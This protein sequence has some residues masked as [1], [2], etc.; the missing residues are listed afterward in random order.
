MAQQHLARHGLQTGPV[1]LA[2]IGRTLVRYCLGEDGVVEQNRLEL[3]LTIQYACFHPG[4]PVAYVA[5]SNGGV[6]IQGDRHC[7]AQVSLG[8]T[9]MRIVAEP[10]VLP[11]RPLHASVG[12]GRNRL[13]IAYNRPAAVTIHD[14]DNDGG[15]VPQRRLLAEGTDR[16]GHFPH[17]VI[18]M[19]GS[20]GL[21]LTCRGDDAGTANAENPGSLRV[22]RDEGETLA[23]VQAVAPN[24]GFGF[25]PRNCAF[26]PQG[27]M[28]YAVLER[29][30]RL[31]AFGYREGLIEAQPS[32]E[33]GL[34][35][36]PGNVRRPQLGG[37]IVIHP[38]GRYAYVVNRAHP[39]PDGSG[40]AAA[41]GENSIVV[42]RLDGLTGEPR[43]MQRLAL[44]GLH[45]RCLA[46]APDGKVLVAA[47]RQPGRFKDDYGRVVECRAGFATFSIGNT[48]HLT[49]IRQ[50]VVDVGDD[51][52]FWA[53]FA[54]I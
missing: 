31:A 32:W 34:L 46:L 26:H 49:L 20:Q 36:N 53:D 38:T 8:D 9:G 52:L 47:L 37:A 30:N 25:G 6:A 18:P 10:A 24:A 35:D 43:E 42:F 33:L 41:C 39:V 5:C 29:Q 11:Y 27:H 40:D 13:A 19:P 22:L 15:L 14:L 1:L 50:D 51:K 21:L 3:P 54:P 45:A 28:L 2:S 4:R 16:V 44:N 7:L 23:C 48:G 12:A 17:Q